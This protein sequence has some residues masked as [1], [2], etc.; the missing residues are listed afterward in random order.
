MG[1]QGKSIAGGDLVLLRPSLKNEFVVRKE[2]PQKGID[3]RRAMFLCSQRHG[4]RYWISVGRVTP[5]LIVDKRKLAAFIPLDPTDFDTFQEGNEFA[6][7]GLR[8]LAVLTMESISTVGFAR[9]L[10]SPLPVVKGM[11]RASSARNTK[12]NSARLRPC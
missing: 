11:P 10:L 6:G 1:K 7:H 4:K 9:D 5:G 8:F 12:P 2:S 3:D